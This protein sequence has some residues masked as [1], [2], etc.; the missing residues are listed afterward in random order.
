MVGRLLLVSCAVSGV[1][2]TPMSEVSIT[3]LGAISWGLRRS[4]IR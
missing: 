1:V 4:L 2:S 3:M